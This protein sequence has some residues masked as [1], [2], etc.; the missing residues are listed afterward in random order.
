MIYGI[1]TDI[2]AVE[3]LAGMFERH[4][5]NAAAKLLAPAE[6]ADFAAAPDK[7][8]F[9]PNASRPRKPSPRRSVSASVRQPRCRQSLSA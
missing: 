5:E 6:M 3:R 1:G 8:R 9:L 4:G 7:G 2:V